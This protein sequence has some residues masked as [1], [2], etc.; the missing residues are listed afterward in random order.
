MEQNP[1]V[2]MLGSPA[3]GAGC[4]TN[5]AGDAAVELPGFQGLS[6][7]LAPSHWQLERASG[8]FLGIISQSSFTQKNLV[9]TIQ[10]HPATQT[11]CRD[12]QLS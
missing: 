5:S 4:G 12:V 9:G 6:F 1:V 10:N 7:G 8:V 3:V 11:V 2:A